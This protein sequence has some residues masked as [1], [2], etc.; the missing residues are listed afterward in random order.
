M[1]L[2]K[3]QK[4]FLRK[5]EIE[6][7]QVFD[8][9]G[10]PQSY[11]RSVMKENGYVVATGVSK[12]RDGHDSLR[13]RS[14]Y[15]AMC[16]P[17]SLSFQKRHTN[18]GDLYVMRSRSTKLIKVGVAD[19]AYDRVITLNK[20]AYGDIKDWELAH[21]IRVTNAGYA[22][23]VIHR[24]LFLHSSERYFYKGGVMVLAQE[25]FSCSVKTAIKEIELLLKIDS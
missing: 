2:S 8:A 22:E 7:D 16:N 10:Y 11:Y 13:T 21:T 5:H 4:D 3:S 14:G 17:A 25:I 20:Q 12:C 18:I 15:C 9:T 23:E 24:R 19:S 1:K 6:D